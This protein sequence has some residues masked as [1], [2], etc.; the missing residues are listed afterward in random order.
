MREATVRDPLELLK[1]ASRR[2]EVPPFMVMDVMAAAERIERAGGHV[3]HME[4][5]QPAAPAPQPA[6]EAPQPELPPLPSETPAPVPAP[7]APNPD[8]PAA[9]PMPT[10]EPAPAPAPEPAQASAE[11]APAETAGE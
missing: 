10:P 2:S 5:G 8:A 6:P 7:E 11:P 1:T 3:I 4:V 9:P